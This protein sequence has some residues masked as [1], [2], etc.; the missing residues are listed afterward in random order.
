MNKKLIYS[1]SNVVAFTIPTLGII[2]S[3]AYLSYCWY[4]NQY[5]YD[6]VHK[7]INIIIV[8]V[9]S[10]LMLSSVVIGASFDKDK[11]A[12]RLFVN[13]LGLSF[14]L[15]VF[16]S[17][18][19]FKDIVIKN[20]VALDSKLIENNIGNVLSFLVGIGILIFSIYKLSDII[21]HSTIEDEISSINSI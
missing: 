15:L 5:L 7:N 16:S 6:L 19:L 8:F 4:Q 1:V 2:G 9:S 18:M 14:G 3:L 17:S 13:I 12:E 11:N 10:F 20:N 21:R